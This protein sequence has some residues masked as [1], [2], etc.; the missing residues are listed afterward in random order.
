VLTPLAYLLSDA[1]CN[2][3]TVDPSGQYLLAAGATGKTVELFSID[4]VT[5]AL[6]YQNKWTITGTNTP[7]PGGV[8]IAKLP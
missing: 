7:Y 2:Q 5:G 8:F 1:Y 6:T 3:V 4:Q